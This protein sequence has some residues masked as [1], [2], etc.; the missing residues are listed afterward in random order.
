MAKIG[1]RGNMNKLWKIALKRLLFRVLN[2]FAGADFIRETYWC[3]TVI[4][5]QLWITVP[6]SGKPCFPAAGFGG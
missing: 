5:R 3:E 2:N 1:D 6:R 4:N